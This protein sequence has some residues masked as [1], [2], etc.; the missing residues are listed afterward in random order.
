MLLAPIMVAT[1]LYA[2][3]IVEIPSW[4]AS[5]PRFARLETGLELARYTSRRFLIPTMMVGLAETP[6]L[7]WAV[8]FATLDA[9]GLVDKM[10]FA[11]ERQAF[12]DFNN[13]VQP[14][15]ARWYTHLTEPPKWPDGDELF[16]NYV[17]HPW[18]GYQIHLLYR[19]HGA[20]MVESILWVVFWAFFWEFIAEA[21]FEH[22]SGNDLVAN[23]AG[24][25]MG[26][27]AWRAK[28]LIM[29]QMRPGFPRNALLAIIDPVGT[30]EM[31]LF[32]VAESHAG[33]GPV[34]RWLR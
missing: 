22:P 14:S 15:F 11:A 5:L 2:T 26:E 4:T 33:M 19:N 18:V 10:P 27:A 17:V 8:S 23:F 28:Q 32:D 21:G 25:L 7:A 24:G 12:W 9:T 1:A 6:S 34:V 31:L 13:W 16:V 20:S 29:D 3:P 30:L